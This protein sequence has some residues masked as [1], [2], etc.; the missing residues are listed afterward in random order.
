VELTSARLARALAL[1]HLGRLAEARL[2]LVLASE[3]APQGQVVEIATEAADM[4][5]F[6]GDPARAA[7][8]LQS[9][10]PRV[11]EDDDNGARALWLRAIVHAASGAF[12]DA[13]EDLGSIA[14]GAP[15]STPVFELRR[16]LAWCLV[17]VLAGTDGAEEQCAAAEGLATRQGARLWVRYASLLRAGADRR[18]TPS[19]VVKHLAGADPVVLSMAAEAVVSRLGELDG[20]SFNA[21]VA[22]AS[23]RPE[24]WRAAAR[25]LARSGTPHEGQAAILLDQIGD[26][27]DVPLLR[28]LAKARR[29]RIEGNVG[30]GLARR[31]APHVLIDDLGR[32]RV[33]I[34]E[35]VM[36]ASEIRRKVLALLCL[37]MTKSAWTA[38]REE[39]VDALWPDQDPQSALNSLN[40]TVYFLRRVF[41]PN[42][43]EE[44]SPGYVQQDG[45]TIW[46]DPDLVDSRSRRCLALIRSMPGDPTPEGALA[47]AT[48]YR[49]R[50]AMDFAYE[51]WA[52]TY[53]DALHASYLRVVEH[54]VRIDLDTGHFA[55]G[56]FIAERAAEIDPDIEEI[57]IALVRLYRH[58]GAHAAAA[59]QYGH[60]AATMRD[61]GVEPVSL[62][63]L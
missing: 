31:L 8:H 14:A 26:A 18:R 61:L 7:A 29:G 23:T 48:E 35:R 45:E 39:V 9:I 60:Y 38:T 53:R 10:S 12:G 40:Q 17:G 5:A 54:A 55:R 13:R 28:S 24:R 33:A 2:E 47:L 4:E 19:E 32:V 43:T 50:F 6:Y 62:A 51:D 46:I 22:E 44:V 3:Q 42:Y 57:Q 34:G 16:Q 52:S 1:A 11:G 30:R 15:R 59:E 27:S 41:E 20:D 56:T 37:L 49:G 25:R 21:V 36:E 63:D 58:S